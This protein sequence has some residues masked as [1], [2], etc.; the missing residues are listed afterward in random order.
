MRGRKPKPKPVF[1][2]IQGGVP[3]IVGVEDAPPPPEWLS[4][5]A[6][7]EWRRV[8]RDM[9]VR[10]TLARVDL[11]TLAAY[12]QAFGRWEV[13]E[14]ALAAMGK[15]DPLT[16]GM[17]IKTTNGNAVQNPMV[18]TANVAARDMVRFA[19]ELGMT[20]VARARAEARGAAAPSTKPGMFG[21]EEA[22]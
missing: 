16:R 5:E 7:S 13:A 22:I 20:P 15:N 11:Q 8:I 19:A 18:G 1:R 9:V 2:V 17:M 14:R 4:V 10:E 21:G 12:C 3:R 6:Q